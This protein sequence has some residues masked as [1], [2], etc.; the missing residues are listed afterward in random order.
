MSVCLLCPRKCKVDRSRGELGFCRVGNAMRVSRYSLHMWEEPPVSAERG[1]G[2]IFFAGC[3]LRCEFC[4]NM[5]ISHGGNPGKEVSV[6][7]LCDIMLELEDMGAENINLVTPTHF[8]DKIALT[9]EKINDKLT[10]PVVYNSSGYESVESL[11]RL[12]GLVDVYLP[13]Y[14]YFSCDLAK[15]Y[16]SAPNYR[17]IAETAILEMYRQAGSAVLDERGVIRKGLIVRHLILPSHRHDSMEIVKRLSLLLPKKDFFVSLMSQYTPDFAI[18]ANSPHKELHRRLT[19]FEYS[20]VVDLAAS[21]GL[22][23]FCQDRSSAVASFTPDFNQ[24]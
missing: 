11:S 22:S 1:S 19:S 10:I 14:K 18:E 20:S 8:S 12:E 21:L 2:T 17:E 15:K 5:S 9:L 24:K 23:G 6:D 16:S 13:D 4:Q 3:N 7:G